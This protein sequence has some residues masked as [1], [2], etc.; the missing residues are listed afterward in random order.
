MSALVTHESAKVLARWQF[1]PYLSL[2]LPVELN[3]GL[4]RVIILEGDCSYLV[5]D[6]L[7]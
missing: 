4:I 7:V 6:L 2:L 3:F 5:A 1:C